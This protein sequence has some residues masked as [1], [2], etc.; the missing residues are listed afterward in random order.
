MDSSQ[1]FKTGTD[2]G[3][4]AQVVW[5]LKSGCPSVPSLKIEVRNNKA[6]HAR[7]ILVDKGLNH[8]DICILTM[9]H[10][11]DQHVTE[12]VRHALC[13]SSPEHQL[14]LVSEDDTM[15]VKMGQK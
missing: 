4:E 1:A 2:A 14:C 5:F 3:Q 15:L 9:V 11:A 13:T 6:V 12:S 7:H 10:V 8:K